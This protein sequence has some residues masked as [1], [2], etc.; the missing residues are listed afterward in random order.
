MLVIISLP[1]S[2]PDIILQYYKSIIWDMGEVS[3][4]GG[5]DFEEYGGGDGE[6]EEEWECEGE[7]ERHRGR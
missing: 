2:H 6:E 5:G 1:G 3:G 7:V 4:V